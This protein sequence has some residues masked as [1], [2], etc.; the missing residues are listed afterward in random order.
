[1]KNIKFIYFDVGGVLLLDYS[2]TNKWVEMR[3]DLGI[4]ADLD[5]KFAQVWKKYESRICI[6]YDADQMV[7]EI[8]KATGVEWP[9]DY[10]LLED[11]VN[12]FEINNSIWSIVD[13][14]KE[15]YRI[16][17]F[18]NQYPRMLSLIKSKNLIP[19]IK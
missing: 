9:K 4:T 7:S 10:S 5:K 8:E 3:R 2:G 15:K 1:M 18:T 14:V 17:L 16:G 6:D 11:F 19:N 13:K 12:R